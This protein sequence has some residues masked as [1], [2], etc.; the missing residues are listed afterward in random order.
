MTTT[1]GLLITNCSQKYHPMDEYI[2]PKRAAKMRSKYGEEVI[3]S[4]DKPVS[5]NFSANNNMDSD[6]DSVKS[7]AR[8]T[9]RRKL[10]SSQG[11]RRSSRHVNKDVLYNVKIHPQDIEIR[12]LEANEARV[13]RR[14]RP[15]QNSYKTSADEE[16]EDE[17]DNKQKVIGDGANDM[18]R[19]IPN[20]D[21][22]DSAHSE[23]SLTV[24]TGI[25]P[26]SSIGHNRSLDG[27]T[28]RKNLQLYPMDPGRRFF[29][30]P[31]DLLGS[32][33]S[34]YI[35]TESLHTQLYAE[36]SARPPVNFEHDDKENIV[37][38]PDLEPTPDPHDS[39]HVQSASEYRQQTEHEDE[40]DITQNEFE[41]LIESFDQ[42]SPGHILDVDGAADDHDD[43]I[44]ELKRELD[45]VFREMPPENSV[46]GENHGPHPGLCRDDECDSVLGFPS[47]GDTVTRECQTINTTSPL[48]PLR[49]VTGDQLT[50]LKLPSTD[51]IEESAATK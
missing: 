41:L 38:N 43:G 39:I 7:D 9:K 48:A 2:Q 17:S 35:H 37:I 46:I 50:D 28:R 3:A 13:S 15:R 12:M 30:R 33:Q 1:S 11:T 51:D 21:E 25:P 40:G 20:T 49:T 5:S 6:S 10:S 4:D 26:L 27:D 36:T 22:S 14:D 24:S 44:V 18:D 32:G 31:D 47:S 29:P 23:H 16:S 34:F 45:S 19:I 42:G 8:A